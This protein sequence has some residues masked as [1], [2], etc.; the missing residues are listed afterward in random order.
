MLKII[1]LILLGLEFIARLFA[2]HYKDVRE[3]IALGL[4]QNVED[5]K[6]NGAKTKTALAIYFILFI[7]ILFL[8]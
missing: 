1:I 7:L 5:F 4:Q 3:Q 8:C 6:V 2:Y